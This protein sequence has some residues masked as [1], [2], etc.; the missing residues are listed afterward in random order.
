MPKVI[1]LCGAQ[2]SGKSTYSATLGFVVHSR[3]EVRAR[4]RAADPG[5][6]EDVV[7]RTFLEE[8]AATVQAGYSVVLDSTLANPK[9]RDEAV[10]FFKAWTDEVE[11]HHVQTSLAVCHQR[12]NVRPAATKVEPTDIDRTYRQIK[13]AFASNPPL[14]PVI[15]V[16]GARG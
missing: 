12:N 6:S 5:I 11:I 7:W 15:N 4:L 16:L 8:A 1:L 13:E 9:R 2:A 14:C 3:D 10:M